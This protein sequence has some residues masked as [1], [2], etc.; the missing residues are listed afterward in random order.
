MKPPKVLKICEDCGWCGYVDKDDYH[1]HP[2]QTEAC[3]NGGGELVVDETNLKYIVTKLREEK[4][5]A[6]RLKRRNKRESSRTKK[7]PNRKNP[8]PTR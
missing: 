5:E 3:L 8:T 6:Q 1:L 7:D 2:G 4:R